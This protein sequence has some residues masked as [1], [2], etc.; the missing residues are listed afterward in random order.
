MANEQEGIDIETL[1]PK[2]EGIYIPDEEIDTQVDTEVEE[3][4]I[5]D[6]NVENNETDTTVD[7]DKENLKK[8]VNYE[9]KLRKE[10]EKKNKELEARIKALEESNKTPEK[11]TL[12]E[13]IESGIDESIAKSIA[14][15]IDKKQSG[16]KQTEKELANLKFQLSLS[17]TSKKSGFEDIADYAD[18]IKD[19]VDKGLTIEQSY[20][21]LTGGKTINSNSEIERKLEAKLENKQA[22]KEILGNINKSV[23]TTVV[24]NKSKVQA[25]A[26][27]IAI[28]KAAGMS[29]E[30]YL[31]VKG[32]DNVK[33]YAEYSKRG[34]K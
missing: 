20:Y 32:I 25:T 23:G 29:I 31:A 8:G 4:E 6:N 3:T 17:E 24:Q 13:L 28:A 16:A 2:N 11:T 15:A 26:E 12:E 21:A 33:E 9:R 10:A 27:E 30:D 5:I 1:N 34:K 19:L 18:D 22:R 7:T 14:S